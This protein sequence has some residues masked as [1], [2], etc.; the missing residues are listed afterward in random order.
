[1]EAE[2]RQG[3]AIEQ[4]DLDQENI[5]S[6]QDHP[7]NILYAVVTTCFTPAVLFL[8]GIFLQTYRPLLNYWTFTVVLAEVIVGIT[9]GCIC[10]GM[11]VFMTTQI[12]MI[13]LIANMINYHL[14]M[15]HMISYQLMP[16][17]VN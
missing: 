7:I 2:A 4:E 17:P 3:P 8:L 1:M 16:I 13:G 6:E 14:K 9:L 11:G 5:E 10:I 15:P 12:P